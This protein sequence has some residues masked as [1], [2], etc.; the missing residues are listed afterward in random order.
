MGKISF[1]NTNNPTIDM[2]AVINFPKVLTNPNPGR[3]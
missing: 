1:T 2:S 3:W